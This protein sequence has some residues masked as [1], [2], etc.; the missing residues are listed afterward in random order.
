[1][2]WRTDCFV[3][4]LTVAWFTFEI[5]TAVPQILSAATSSPHLPGTGAVFA[6]GAGQ[7]LA[8]LRLQ[9]TGLTFDRSVFTPSGKKRIVAA[10]T[11]SMPYEICMNRITTVFAPTCYQY[12]FLQYDKAPRVRLTADNFQEVYVQLLCGAVGGTDPSGTLVAQ[13]QIE[14]PPNN[15]SATTL[16]AANL[17]RHNEDDTSAFSAEVFH[18]EAAEAISTTSSHNSAQSEMDA[19]VKLR[20]ACRCVICGCDGRVINNEL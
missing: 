8:S 12:Y 15:C 7:S 4:A 19:V 9:F 17:R 18:H 20:D 2:C 10:L 1:V 14:A 3:I 6:V 5:V 13:P 11:S 16:T